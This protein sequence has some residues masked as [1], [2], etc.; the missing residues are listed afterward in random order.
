MEED[1]GSTRE[2]INAVIKTGQCPDAAQRKESKNTVLEQLTSKE[3]WCAKESC[4]GLDKAICLTSRGIDG[5]SKGEVGG[6]GPSNNEV[7]SSPSNN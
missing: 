1:A 7:Q 3:D 4:N 5:D 6:F 2:K